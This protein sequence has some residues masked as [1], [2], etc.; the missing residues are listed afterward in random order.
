M[1]TEVRHGVVQS[2]DGYEVADLG[3]KFV[4]YREGDHILRFDKD[5]GSTR[6]RYYLRGMPCWQPPFEDEVISD[7]KA[8]EIRS[9]VISAIRYWGYPY[10]FDTESTSGQPPEGITFVHRKRPT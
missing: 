2:S 1:F 4:T 7:T 10:E 6:A 5:V 3:M 8:S 9:R